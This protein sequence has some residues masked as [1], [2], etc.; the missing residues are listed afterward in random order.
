MK[1]FIIAVL[2]VF[3]GCSKNTPNVSVEK[4]EIIPSPLVVGETE[5]LRSL[6][7][8]PEHFEQNIE[9]VIRL[10]KTSFSF[11]RF[12]DALRYPDYN[13]YFLNSKKLEALDRIGHL[14]CDKLDASSYIQ[15]LDYLGRKQEFQDSH[16]TII[17]L[18]AN[19]VEYCRVSLPPGQLHETFE[20]FNSIVNTEPNIEKNLTF[21]KFI[22]IISYS[23]SQTI[24]EVLQHKFTRTFT[25]QIVKS[26][27]EANDINSA[28]EFS[29]VLKKIHPF[30]SD[31]SLSP[32]KDFITSLETLKKV[33]DNLNLKELEYIIKVSHP[34]ILNS[35]NIEWFSEYFLKKIKDYYLNIT[36]RTTDFYEYLI[37]STETFLNIYTTYNK[38]INQQLHLLEILAD[39]IPRPLSKEA[40]EILEGVSHGSIIATTALFKSQTQSSLELLKL[41]DSTREIVQVANLFF[42]TRLEKD[43]LKAHQTSERICQIIGIKNINKLQDLTELPQCFHLVTN[44]ANLSYNRELSSSFF[45]VLKIDGVNLELKKNNN[46][47]GIINLSSTKIIPREI[48]ETKNDTNN[49]I[50]VPLI[51][52]FKSINRTVNF[53]KNSFYYMNYHYIAQEALDGEKTPSNLKPLKGHS[54]GNLNLP[55]GQKNP[56]TFIS[57]GSEGQLPPE[58]IFPGKQ[59]S[60]RFQFTAVELWLSDILD[61]SY[62]MD[63]SYH[64]KSN[65]N[66]L[67]SVAERNE[68]NELKVYV[69][70]A[71]T[72]TLTDS[73]T[74]T[75]HHSLNRLNEIRNWD[76]PDFECKLRKATNE[77]VSELQRF[78]AANDFDSIIKRMKESYISSPANYGQT[79]EQGEAGDDGKI[80][81]SN[82]FIN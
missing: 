76:C 9:S 10:M 78:Y 18:I 71:F 68:D 17:K 70:P 53:E 31:I 7:L 6:M 42:K 11:H 37:D 74:F 59:Y 57:K 45:S 41:S 49:A 48:I 3:V 19:F 40:L 50:G 1:L 13:I 62:F 56:L 2:A 4:Q 35:S 54:G 51:F 20:T 44:K 52:G 80:F 23:E 38:S 8:E 81:T 73:A 46:Q 64:R 25:S 34:L 14:S 28:I 72:E 39:I 33:G 15:F 27:Q 5:A 36:N 77:A 61:I 69:D 21:I 43:M 16:H 55:N 60:E 30:D 67:F 65:I 82:D 58:A 26:I 79:F 32:I 24:K 12:W 47:L 22:K 63:D 29:I 75:L 66:R